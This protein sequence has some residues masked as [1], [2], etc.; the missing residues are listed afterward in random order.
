MLF[1]VVD[2][3]VS[4]CAN[5]GSV[6]H[7]EKVNFETAVAHLPRRTR[8]HGNSTNRP[9]V[10]KNKAYVEWVMFGTASLVKS[11]QLVLVSI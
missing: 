5:E 2:L 9:K 4:V 3:F 1:P 6:C 11:Y 8:L 10:V 7:E